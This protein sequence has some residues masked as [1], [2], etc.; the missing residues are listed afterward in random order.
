MSLLSFQCKKKC[1]HLW[2]YWNSSVSY[3]MFI[4][5]IQ[6]NVI[7]IRMSSVYMSTS[8]C[9]S[10]PTLCNT[11]HSVWIQGGLFLSFFLNCT[12]RDVWSLT[13]HWTNCNFMYKWTNCNNNNISR[14]EVE[15]KKDT[16]KYVIPT[17]TTDRNVPRH[18]ISHSKTSPCVY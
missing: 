15:E 9:S 1:K 16:I 12:T 18:W 3:L 7:I 6:F 11:L 5:Y 17:V 4:V 10:W 2:F 8:C 13:V 14:C